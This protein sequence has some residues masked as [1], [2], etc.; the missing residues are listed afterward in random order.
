MVFKTSVDYRV[1][2]QL[3]I[4]A[5]LSIEEEARTKIKDG[6]VMVGF[7][8]IANPKVHEILKENEISIR[9]FCKTFS[10]EKEP[11]VI[12]LVAV[13]EF[14]LE[15]QNYMKYNQVLKLFRENEEFKRPISMVSLILEIPNEIEELFSYHKNI[16]TINNYYQSEEQYRR[17]IEELNEI[18]NKQSDNIRNHPEKLLTWIYYNYDPKI[19]GL[20]DPEIINELKIWLQYRGCSE[21][22]L[23][24]RNWN[25]VFLKDLESSIFILDIVENQLKNKAKH[26]EPWVR[27]LMADYK[28]QM[29]L[30]KDELIIKNRIKH[31]FEDVLKNYDYLIDPEHKFL[32]YVYW[33]ALNAKVVTEKHIAE[34]YKIVNNETNF[35]PRSWIVRGGENVRT[36]LIELMQIK[37]FEI[38][39]LTA[40]SLSELLYFQFIFERK[41]IEE[42]WIG[43]KFWELAK[44]KEHIW[45]LKYIRGMAFCRLNWEKNREEW[46]KAIKAADTEKLQ[47]TWCKVIEN[48]GYNEREDRDAFFNILLNILE[49]GTNF[50]EP[51]RIAAFHRLYGMV[52]EI[53]PVGFDEEKLNLPLSRR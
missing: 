23:S 12:L 50:A 15:P 45:N 25:V 51:I 26:L 35:P 2:T 9:K 32:G 34:L 44:N 48:A 13:F 4:L 28:W 24:I 22:V 30:T 5:Y 16:Y 1:N 3:S 47:K 46:F 29:P 37:T 52:S 10:N 21:K 33:S 6:S 42:S 17:D 49:S 11:F 38:T 53:E 40:E 41:I 8:R 36:S 43:D 20:L 31:I 14:L 27:L 39:C 18:A 19:E 7:P